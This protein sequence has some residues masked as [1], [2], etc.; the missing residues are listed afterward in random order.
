MASRSR[1]ICVRGAVWCPF[2]S[3]IRKGA[4]LF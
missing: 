3:L 4:M 2:A 1:P